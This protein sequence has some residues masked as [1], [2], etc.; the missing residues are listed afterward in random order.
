MTASG[1]DLEQLSEG[2]LADRLQEAG[3]RL[4][5]EIR[6]VI[7]GQETVVEQALIAL[8]GD[9]EHHVAR[10]AS[11]PTFVGADA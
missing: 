4:A 5:S 10:F 3:Q 8:F 1:S 2:E 11:L 6:K 9:E 7:V